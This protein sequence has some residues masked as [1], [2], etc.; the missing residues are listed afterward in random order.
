[1]ENLSL[2]GYGAKAFMLSM[3]ETVLRVTNNTANPVIIE[4]TI[5][6]GKELLAKPIELLDEPA[7]EP[8]SCAQTTEHATE[9]IKAANWFAENSASEGLVPRK[10]STP[11]YS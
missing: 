5:E 11:H 10:V 3:V 2:Y 6:Y 7:D 8:P 1:M 9:R 4:K